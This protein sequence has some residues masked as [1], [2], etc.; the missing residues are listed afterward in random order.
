V[1]CGFAEVVTVGGNLSAGA[2]CRERY[3]GRARR[4]AALAALN[5]LPHW[6]RSTRCR[7]GRAQRAVVSDA[8]N[9][10]VVLGALGPG[11]F[12]GILSRIL[13]SRSSECAG[14]SS[15][16]QRFNSRFVLM[17]L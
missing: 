9:A 10:L 17:L 13:L 5:A 4:A 7:T 2:A 1:D 6:T 8:L 11:F 3:A 12:A 15:A 16:I 14:L